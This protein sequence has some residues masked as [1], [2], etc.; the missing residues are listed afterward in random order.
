MEKLRGRD[1]HF[2]L[3]ILNGEGSDTHYIIYYQDVAVIRPSEK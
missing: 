1:I 2:E 3:S